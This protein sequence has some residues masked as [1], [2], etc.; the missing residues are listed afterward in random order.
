MKNIGQVST[1]I[2]LAGILGL[3]FLIWQR[4]PDP[5]PL[6]PT[7]GDFAALKGNTYALQALRKRLPLVETNANITNSSISV[8][9]NITNSSIPVDANITNHLINVLPL[10]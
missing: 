7:L 9:A 4:T 2:L 8:D 1:N 3:L 5:S 6:A 10:R